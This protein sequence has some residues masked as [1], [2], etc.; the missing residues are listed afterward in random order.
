MPEL[1]GAEFELFR[2]FLHRVAGIS[3][4]D[5]KRPLVSGRL[6]KRLQAC[7]CG[8]YEAYY[9]LIAD[10]GCAEETQRALDLLTTNETHFFRESDH[11][12]VLTALARAAKRR[13]YRVWC[14]ASSSGEEPYSIAMTLA[15]A[16]GLQSDW[17]VLASDLSTRMLQAASHACYP[18]EDAARIPPALLRRYCLR[19]IGPQSGT[20]LIERTLRARVQFRQINLNDA[21]PAIGTFDCVFLRNVMIYFDL[22]MKRKV[23][24]KIAACLAPGGR[25]VIGHAESLQGVT[26]MLVQRAPTV[27]GRSDEH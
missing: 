23:A 3:L 27:Y 20:F 10:G 5:S 7:N 1:S 19:G 12:R 2:S 11:F 25:L 24:E 9:H 21:F 14:A 17:Q 18:I 15:E 6:A 16:L 8:S 26:P 13:P 4:S 22:A